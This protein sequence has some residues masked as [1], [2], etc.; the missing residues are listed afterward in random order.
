MNWTYGKLKVAAA[1]AFLSLYLYVRTIPITQSDTYLLWFL[2]GIP[3]LVVLLIPRWGQ[4]IARGLALGQALVFG[5]ITGFGVVVGLPSWLSTGAHTLEFAAYLAAFAT[6]SVLLLCAA[7]MQPELNGVYDKQSRIA[8][9][10]AAAA[11]ALLVVDMVRFA[12]IAKHNFA[13][14]GIYRV[15]ACAESYA[16]HNHGEYPESI[17]V[18]VAQSKAWFSPNCIYPFDERG[19]GPYGQIRYMPRK[20]ADGRVSG[21]SISFGPQTFFGN[22]P[23]A[24]YVDQ[25][26]VVHKPKNH[27]I[28]TAADPVRENI[29]SH[30]WTWGQC[31][32]NYRNS[33]PG[34]AFPE[35][36]NAMLAP[37][38][39]CKP[40]R[41]IEGDHLMPDNTY[42]VYYKSPS[43]AR[44]NDPTSF[45][46]QARPN[47]YRESG[48]R[49]YYMGEDG[50]I[51][52][53]I[54]NRSANK[55]D[56][57]IPRCE[58]DQGTSCSE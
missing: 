2:D 32:V 19:R 24:E 41:A 22:L 16:E 13:P 1:L 8:W 43:E 10:S 28:A 52:A 6:H 11:I 53:T 29:S 35:N 7:R 40:H 51:R 49:S 12:D 37:D 33:H 46:L 30:L 36:V 56:T 47:I 55:S 23:T 5:L 48:I 58:W 50:I 54:K 20:T 17:E 4:S 3:S 27:A 26:G 21:Y 45:S 57:P 42:T 39:P 44:P 9:L 15:I 14:D 34:A 31:F 25:T 18:M 38:W